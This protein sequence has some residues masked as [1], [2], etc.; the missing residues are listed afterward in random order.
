MSNSHFPVTL[1]L[2]IYYIPALLEIYLLPPTH[3]HLLLYMTNFQMNCRPNNML[4]ALLIF[5]L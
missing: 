3:A 2:V 1:L 4:L 5:K